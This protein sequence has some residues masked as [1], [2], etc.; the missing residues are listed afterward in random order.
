[1]QYQKNADYSK[2]YIEATETAI[3]SIHDFMIRAK[4]LSVAMANSTY[5]PESREAA[6][7]EVKEILEAV[8]NIGN[9]TY[10]NRFVFGGFRTTTPPLSADGQF[11]GDDGA[12]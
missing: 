6:A 2:G 7:R 8:V 9:T 3:A 1:K 5:G 12:I 4:E 11:V 10:G